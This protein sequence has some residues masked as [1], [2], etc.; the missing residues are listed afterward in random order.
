LPA[1]SLS[2]SSEKSSR[3]KAS[4]VNVHFLRGGAAT[5][6]GEELPREFSLTSFCM[7]ELKSVFSLIH[8]LLRLGALGA[9]KTSEPF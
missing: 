2:E 9:I 1:L 4:W 8:T 7:I 5:R 3:S 6:I